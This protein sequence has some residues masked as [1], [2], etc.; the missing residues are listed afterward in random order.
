MK[1]EFSYKVILRNVS[2]DLV[3]ERFTNLE[4]LERIIR[5]SDLVKDFK[6]VL[7]DEENNILKYEFTENIKIF[8]GVLK[9][10]VKLQVE[11]VKDSKNKRMVYKSRTEDGL[12]RITKIRRFSKIFERGEEEGEEDDGREGTLVEESIEGEF[13]GGLWL[14]RPLIKKIASEAHERHMNNYYKILQDV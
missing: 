7:N 5:L 12:S 8:F 2:V 9:K 10:D 14:F 1:I 11:Q 3:F 6:M 4:Y 13:W